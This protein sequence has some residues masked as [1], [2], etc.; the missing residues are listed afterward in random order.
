MQC[1]RCLPL[2]TS[3]TPAATGDRNDRWP[4]LHQSQA[5]RSR[6][7][8][9]GGG[10]EVFSAAPHASCNGN[11]DGDVYS[12]TS[13]SRQAWE[14]SWHDSRSFYESENEGIGTG[15]EEE[16]VE[17][18]GTPGGGRR[19][20]RSLRVA[21]TK[22][23]VRCRWLNLKVERREGGKGE[24]GQEGCISKKREGP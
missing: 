1:C 6:V 22:L 14:K 5:C 13:P 7:R 15:D 9:G 10:R 16:M 12:E 19:A 11:F 8:G 23:D 17:K 18:M 20:E 3:K 4:H 2:L 24:G 21:E